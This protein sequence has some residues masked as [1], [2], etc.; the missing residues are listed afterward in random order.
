MPRSVFINS[1]LCRLLGADTEER[2][3]Q[4][5]KR[6]GKQLKSLRFR[7][8]TPLLDGDVHMV[9]CWQHPL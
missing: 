8:E 5:G 3:G 7:R 2:G 9:I 4:G 6:V 1:A